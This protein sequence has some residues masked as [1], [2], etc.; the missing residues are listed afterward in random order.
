M[1]FVWYIQLRSYRRRIND[2][3]SGNQRVMSFPLLLSL[4]K[5]DKQAVFHL[6]GVNTLPHVDCCVRGTKPDDP[7]AC[8]SYDRKR[9][10]E[11]EYVE[12]KKVGFGTCGE[13]SRT[14]VLGGR[15]FR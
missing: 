8:W 9:I 4:D 13:E 3:C 12:I 11:I 6:K 2:P 1:F 15:D 5:V 14:E 10:G 7:F